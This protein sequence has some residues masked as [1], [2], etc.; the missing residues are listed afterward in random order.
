M[1]LIL[2]SPTMS[3]LTLPHRIR[4]R[5]IEHALLASHY[6]PI[7]LVQTLRSDINIQLACR[8]LRRDVAKVRMRFMW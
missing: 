2:L 7:L 4:Y 6:E 8:Q 3:L 1:V 5:I